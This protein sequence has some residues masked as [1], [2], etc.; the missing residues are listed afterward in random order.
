M[1]IVF[2]VKCRIAV[3]VLNSYVISKD[4][5]YTSGSFH[6]RA[7]PFGYF[8]EKRTKCMNTHVWKSGQNL[9]I[10]SPRKN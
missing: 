6:S 2:K 4:R 1:R 5:A 10:K 3:G 7:F 8:L 9:G